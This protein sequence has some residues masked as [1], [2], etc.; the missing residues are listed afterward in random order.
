MLKNTLFFFFSDKKAMIFGRD[1]FY[2]FDKR[3]FQFPGYQNQRCLYL[4][5]RDFREGNFT[6]M[7][8]RNSLVVLLNDCEITIYRDGRVTSSSKLQRLVFKELPVQFTNTSVSRNTTFI[9]V[10]NTY[11][12]ELACDMKHFVCSITTSGFYHNSTAGW[13]TTQQG[14][15]RLLLYLANFC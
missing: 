11:G 12:F 6:V 9:V 7:T 5:A 1:H 14:K 13:F 10:N 4:A 8:D 15:G 2:T 3:H